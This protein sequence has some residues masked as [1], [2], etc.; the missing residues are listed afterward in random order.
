MRFCTYFDRNLPF[1]SKITAAPFFGPK[2]PISSQKLSQS[3]EF[4]GLFQSRAAG[5][6]LV[7]LPQGGRFFWSPD[8]TP[9]GFFVFRGVAF[10]V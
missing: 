7:M 3:G 5:A 10:G 1:L 4:T 6:A 9:K 8:Q 2:V